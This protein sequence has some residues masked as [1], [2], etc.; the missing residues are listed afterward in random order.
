MSLS[1]D[2]L[3]Q[4]LDSLPQ[5]GCCYLAFSGGLDSCVLLHLLH[6]LVPQ[7][8]YPLQAIHVHHGLQAGADA[9]QQHCEA[10][11]AGYRIPL[12]TLALDLQ[13]KKGHSLEALARAARYQALARQL[14]PGDLLLTAQHQDDQA[15][16]LLLQLLRGGGPAGLAAMPL[17]SEFSPGWLAR[18]L[19]HQSRQSIEA[20]A[21]EKGLRWQEDPSNQ[22]QRFDRNFIRHRVMP[23]LQS[24]W[25]AAPVT[26]ARSARFSGEMLTL[27][28]EEM[29]VELERVQKAQ[30]GSLSV[31]LLRE[32]SSMRIRHLLRFW[33]EL[34]GAPMP[35][36]KKLMRIEK[37]SIHGRE[38]AEPLVVWSGWEIRRYRDDLILRQSRPAEPLPESIYWQ[39]KEKLVLPCELG[40][41]IATVGSAGL[42]R[43]RWQQGKVEVRFRQGG[44]RCVPAGRG[45]HKSLKKLFQE[46]GVPP[47]KRAQTPLIYIDGELAAVPGLVTCEGF[48]VAESEQGILLQISRSIPE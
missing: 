32:M 6:E 39:N 31:A 14:S 23:L 5:A 33:I 28:R 15:E 48:S 37:E 25:P 4:T 20:Y 40:I 16:T 44:E 43:E 3:K 47:W 8:P 1:P 38:D 34:N 12:I 9:W 41:L 11:C 35:N 27:A 18:P 13:P 21:E 19:L 10:V 45:H 2:Q 29:A 36:S 46:R 26:L 17:L 24:R 7:L 22:D 42:D 30:S